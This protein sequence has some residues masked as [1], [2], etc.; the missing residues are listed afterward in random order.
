MT[1]RE[2]LAKV[3]DKLQDILYSDLVAN[4]FFIGTKREV[5]KL[6]GLVSDNDAEVIKEA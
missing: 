1:V 2:L 6:Q 5:N 4:G 3:R